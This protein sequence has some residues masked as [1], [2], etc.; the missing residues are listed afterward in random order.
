M[1]QEECMEA[2]SKHANIKPVI[3]STVWKGLEKENKEFFK[4]YS[5]SKAERAS[6]TEVRQKIHKMVSESH[7]SSSN[8]RV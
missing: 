5:K 4:A 3:T 8:E 6:K 1:S 2:L 7:S